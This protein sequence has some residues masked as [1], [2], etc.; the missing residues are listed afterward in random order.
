MIY[1]VRHGQTDWNVLKKVQGQ[2][3]VE[4]NETGIKQAE[5]IRDELM[6]KDLQTIDRNLEELEKTIKRTNDKELKLKKELLEKI[7]KMYDEKKKY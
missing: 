4:L 3:D 7:K 5:I 2:V 1:I 6:A